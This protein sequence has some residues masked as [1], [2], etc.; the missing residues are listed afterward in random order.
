MVKKLIMTSAPGAAKPTWAEVEA[1]ETVQPEK[2]ALPIVDGRTIVHGDT[3]HER[4][5]APGENKVLWRT[6]NKKEGE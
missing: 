2:T 4:V 6:Q 5:S 1:P 3:I